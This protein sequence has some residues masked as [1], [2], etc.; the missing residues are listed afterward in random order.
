MRNI[1]ITL[2]GV[3]LLSCNQQKKELNFITQNDL[4]NKFSIEIPQNWEINYDTINF[5]SSIFFSNKSKPQKQIVTYG[6]VLDKTEFQI[7]DDF[8][9][10]TDTFMVFTKLE[11]INGRFGQV[12][13]FKTYKL[14][15]VDP[16][17]KSDLGNYETIYYL[18]EENQKGHLWFSIQRVQSKLSKS[19]SILSERILKSIKLN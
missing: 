3:L 12:N 8:G 5:Q 17:T 15:F 18:K 14:D 19:D 11:K 9:K 7:N 2:T 13:T 10:L 6:I 4:K 1:I 16:H